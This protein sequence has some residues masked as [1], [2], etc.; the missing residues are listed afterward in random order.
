M[1]AWGIMQE[2]MHYYT[3]QKA[4]QTQNFRYTSPAQA[5]ITQPRLH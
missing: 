2:N 1:Y 5:N 4:N 3:I